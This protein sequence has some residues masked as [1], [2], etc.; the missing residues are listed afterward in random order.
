[1]NVGVRH[2]HAEMAKA[3]RTL[4]ETIATEVLYL[5]DRTCCICRLAGRKVEIHHIDGDPS[6]NDLDNLAV[7]CKDCHSEAHTTQAFS[8]NLTP[9]LIRKYNQSWRDTVRVRL[10][11]GGEKGLLLEYRYQILLDLF[12]AAHR[13]RD[14]YTSL[15][16]D[17]QAASYYEKGLHLANYWSNLADYAPKKYSEA[18]WKRYLPLFDR[19]NESVAVQIER[20]ISVH[21]EGTPTRIKLAVIRLASR[22]RGERLAYR[23]LPRIVT[24]PRVVGHK[25]L[26]FE[27]RFVDVLESLRAFVGE[28][29]LE[30]QSSDTTNPGDIPRIFSDDAQDA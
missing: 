13:W 11:P 18:E 4:P 15:W 9:S 21:S 22:L 23:D 14:R 28:V 6:N 25:D 3:R 24:D 29:D 1:M 5:S 26:F 7:L 30:R 10:E 17:E 2:L 16:P 27:R 19:T 20:I 8:R 12:M